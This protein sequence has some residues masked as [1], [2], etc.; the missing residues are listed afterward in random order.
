MV[1]TART[2][3]SVAA[4]ARTAGPAAECPTSS[5]G[6][7]CLLRS[8]SAARPSA[9][10]VGVL[11]QGGSGGRCKPEIDGEHADPAGGERGR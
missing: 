7:A 10:Q 11:G 3:G 9:G 8:V 1:T 4:A 6:S 2:P 5:D